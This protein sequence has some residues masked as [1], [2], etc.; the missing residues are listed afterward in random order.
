MVEIYCWVAATRRHVSMEEFLL[1]YFGHVRTQC[2]YRSETI[3]VI[4]A[5]QMRPTTNEKVFAIWTGQR[6][7]K[8]EWGE[9]RG[10]IS[11]VFVM[12]T[13][14]D[15]KRAFRLSVAHLDI[16]RVQINKLYVRCAKCKLRTT[17]R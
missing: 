2:Y 12:A 3:D 7:W 16:H 15:I 11:I 5:K 8:R 4:G 6:D 1:Q 13:M 9:G 14:L 10:E 17:K